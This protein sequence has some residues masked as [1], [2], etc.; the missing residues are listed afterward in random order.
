M[1]EKEKAT[2][3]YFL[4]GYSSSSQKSAWTRTTHHHLNTEQNASQSP[5]LLVP[6]GSLAKRSVL[7][8]IKHLD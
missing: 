2:F 3:R 4:V 1:A 8:K 5:E 6:R 7:I